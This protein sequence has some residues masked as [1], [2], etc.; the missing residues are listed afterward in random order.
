[1][2]LKSSLVM[3]IACCIF[4]C[5][6]NDSTTTNANSNG[7][8]Q[9]AKI[10]TF[11]HQMSLYGEP[12]HLNM[13]NTRTKNGLESN[14]VLQKNT[15]QL[16]FD[17]TIESKQFKQLLEEHMEK[18]DTTYSIEN[19]EILNID[20]YS[21]RTRTLYFLADYRFGS[22]TVYKLGFGIRYGK[23]AGDIRLTMPATI[24]NE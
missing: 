13:Y 16:Q 21:V 2:W 15:E 23:N 7:N 20:Y 17:V 12:H 6:N 3:L 5:S 14:I 22:S 18:Y 9:N 11:V 1:M 8:V 24:V 4:S 19:L 10:D